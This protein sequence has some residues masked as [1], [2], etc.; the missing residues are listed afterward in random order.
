[1][2]PLPDQPGSPDPFTYREVG[3]T[4]AGELPAGYR[5]L[6]YCA[7][8]PADGMPAAVEA[9]FTWRMH[10]GTGLRVVATADRV[11]PGV[12][13]TTSLGLGRLRIQ[14]PC[15]VV[16][17]ATDPERA[18]FGYGTLAGH[19]FQGEES[20]VVSRDAA[21]AVWFTLTSFSRPA[22][23]FARAGGPLTAVAQHVFA[24]RCAASLRAA[25]RRG[26]LA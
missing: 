7:R 1:M 17:V 18:G 20:F 24:R 3:A 13:V 5:H 23:W 26:G 6:S 19:P 10:R 16:W 8:L 21:G 25:Q 9:L 2:T 15:Q 14:V 12:R 22:R 11:S 4:R